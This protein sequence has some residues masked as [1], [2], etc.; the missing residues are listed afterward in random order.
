MG[1]I[2]VLIFDCVLHGIDRVVASH[3]CVAWSLSR[4]R[5]LIRCYMG[6]F[7]VLICDCV[8]HDLYC[9]VDI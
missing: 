6:L 3:C 8:L 9:G 5:Y 2:V 7:A 4:C 1:F